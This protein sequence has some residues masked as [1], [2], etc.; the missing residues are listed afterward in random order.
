M[1]NS[2]S[3]VK[4]SEHIQYMFFWRSQI[5]SDLIDLMPRLFMKINPKLT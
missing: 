3:E 4:Q 5:S 2:E 1:E